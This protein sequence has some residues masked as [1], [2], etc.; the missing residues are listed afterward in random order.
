LSISSFVMTGW[1]LGLGRQHHALPGKLPN[2][3]L[4]KFTS[5]ANLAVVNAAKKAWILA[6]VGN[7]LASGARPSNM[8]AG[9]L[10]PGLRGGWT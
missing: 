7:W 4:R 8:R 9:T 6:V 2:E 10:F 5:G 3:D 1:W